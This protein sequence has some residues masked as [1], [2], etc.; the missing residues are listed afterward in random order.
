MGVGQRCRLRLCLQERLEDDDGDA[1]QNA[2]RPR[3][4]KVLPRLPGTTTPLEPLFLAD[5]GT[6]HE[7]T[8]DSEAGPLLEA[9]GGVGVVAPSPPLSAV[10]L[11]QPRVEFSPDANA[12]FTCG[13]A[14]S[15]RAT[16]CYTPCQKHI[17]AGELRMAWCDKS[18]G[19]NYPRLYHAKCFFAQAHFGAAVN[20]GVVAVDQIFCS[21]ADRAHPSWTQS[22][23]TIREWVRSPPRF[24]RADLG[25]PPAQKKAAKVKATVVMPALALAVRGEEGVGSVVQ[26]A[27]LAAYNVRTFNLPSKP[28][29]VME[30]QMPNAF[31]SCDVGIVK[32]GMGEEFDPYRNLTG[33]PTSNWMHF[34]SFFDDHNWDF[35]AIQEPRVPG[36]SDPCQVLN[37]DHAK[38]GYFFSGGEKRVH[39]VGLAVRRKWLPFTEVHGVDDRIMWARVVMGSQVL[40]ILSVYAPCE[41]KEGDVASQGRRDV[42]YAQLKLTLAKIHELAGGKT[43]PNLIIL[44][45]FN[46]RVGSVQEEETIGYKG[47]LGPH[48]TDTVLT[49][50]GGD[51]ICFCLEN[52]LK[53]ESTFFPPGVSGSGTWHH[54]TGGQVPLREGAACNAE[55]AKRI[56]RNNVDHILTRLSPNVFD[57]QACGALFQYQP[58]P[59][60]HRPVEL[61]LTVRMPPLSPHIPRSPTKAV[62]SKLDFR[63]LKDVATAARVEQ[64]I[65]KELVRL[66][67]EY[68]THTAMD[69]TS[70]DPV[71]L[72]NTV[73]TSECG[74]LLPPRERFKQSP[75]WFDRHRTELTGLINAKRSAWEKVRA[76]CK[77]DRDGT[78]EMTCWRRANWAVTAA[79]RKYKSEFWSGLARDLNVMFDRNDMSG[80]FTAVKRTY[81]VGK[82]G[83]AAFSQG[84]LSSD[85]KLLYVGQKDILARLTEHFSQLLNQDGNA[86]S[87][88]D[89]FGRSQILAT[90]DFTQSQS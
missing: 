65:T 59:S 21:P 11:C 13:F 73:I 39:G 3:K 6:A 14:P 52:N 32:A 4:R 23:E 41:I 31:L 71:E 48:N 53:I 16:C 82:G 80:F 30:G 81:G 57:V 75:E 64:A 61:H 28:S 9:V 18:T 46:A 24:T 86:S 26:H 68:V 74:R 22:E 27:R 5:L 70:G 19:H 12:K 29:Y 84:L 62:K 15:S 55:L 43:A 56:F 1:V 67:E 89:C 42:F 60:D 72:L 54:D 20:R 17:G 34:D 77:E 58:Q 33:D 35:V 87:V 83:G 10:V 37:F 36:C 8:A 50:A 88:Q 7:P 51:L 38:Y 47:I 76:L 44:G 63:K 49:T 66:K 25:L 45:D 78:E 40:F 85:G 90:A 79:C 69:R 2:K